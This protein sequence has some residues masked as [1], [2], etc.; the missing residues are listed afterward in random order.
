VRLGSEVFFEALAEGDSEEVRYQWQF[1]GDDLP[2]ATNS[3]L[4]IA[5]AAPESAGA[6]RVSAYTSADWL[7]SPPAFLSLRDPTVRL[8]LER[9]TNGAGLVLRLDG[10]PGVAYRLESSED[11]KSWTVLTS[12]P[13]AGTSMDLTHD[14]DRFFRAR[15]Q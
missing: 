4:R 9:P 10:S 7:R 14:G 11:F 1:N 2:G 6:Y 12:G 13:I 5:N 8:A 15:L 3:T